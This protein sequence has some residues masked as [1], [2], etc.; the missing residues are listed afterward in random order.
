MRGVEFPLVKITMQ[1]MEHSIVHAMHEHFA[2]MDDACAKAVKAA[3][4][5]FDYPGEVRR[6]AHQMIQEAI[7]RALEKEILYGPTYEKVEEV[8]REIVRKN[9]GGIVTR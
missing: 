5:S 6:M 7:K 4:E 2:Q 1:G 8:A 9:I 3:V